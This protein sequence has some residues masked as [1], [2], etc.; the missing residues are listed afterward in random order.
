MSY[1]ENE[2]VEPGN[3]GEEVKLYGPHKVRGKCRMYAETV[4]EVTLQKDGAGHIKKSSHSVIG[5]AG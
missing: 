5:R 2:N 3:V 1:G 4:E